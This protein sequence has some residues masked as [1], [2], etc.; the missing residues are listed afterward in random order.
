ML[1]SKFPTAPKTHD[2]MTILFQI[3]LSAYATHSFRTVHE[4]I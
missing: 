4:E 1:K 3:F 2:A